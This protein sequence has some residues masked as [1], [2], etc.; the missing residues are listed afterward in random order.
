MSMSDLERLAQRTQVVLFLL[1]YKEDIASTL[2]MHI[3][4]MNRTDTFDDEI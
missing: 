1:T 2:A 4:L 3:W